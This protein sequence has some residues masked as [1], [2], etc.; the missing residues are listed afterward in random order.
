LRRLLLLVL[1]T[2]ASYPIGLALG[3]PWLLPVLNALPAYLT[4]ARALR[5]GKRGAAV[6]AMLVWAAALG[7]C[8][9]LS[10]RFW[11][12]P[13]DA[14]ILH[15]PAYR[16]EMFA[17]IR[18]GIGT[19]G[20]PR[21]F[22]PQHALHAGAFVL[23]S[24]ITASGASIL[25]GAVLMNYMA[26]YVASLGRAGVPPAAVLLLGWQPWALV[27]V[28]SFCVLGVVLAEPLLSRLWRYDSAGLGSARRYLWLAAAGLLADV[29]LKSALA[30]TW[31]HLLQP[32]LP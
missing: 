18:T 12:T 27:R 3:W 7:V 26:F 29:V 31:R 28:A 6:G 13:P 32:L 20:S 22:L 23:L 15:G 25:L 17:W 1:A 24:L 19:E 9:T 14:L 4:M 2:A 30:G 11:P 8:A 10:L 21:A 16:D 5:R